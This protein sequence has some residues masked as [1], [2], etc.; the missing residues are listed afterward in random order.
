[1]GNICRSPA[2]EA[3]FLKL[4]EKENL[5]GKIQVDSAGLLDYHEGESYDSRMIA[6]AAQRGYE[7]NGTS[8]PF[9]LQD[10]EKYDIILAM[11]DEIYDGLKLLD[12]ENR[13]AD[14]IFKMIDFY[15]KKDFKEVPDPYYSNKKGFEIVLNILEDACK[16]LLQKVKKDDYSRN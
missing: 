5:D 15:S 14:K 6:C 13:Y 8:R 1:M 2:A 9:I 16:G 7:L 11:D 3:I 12:K 10:F 4:L